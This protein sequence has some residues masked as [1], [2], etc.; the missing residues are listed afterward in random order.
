MQIPFQYDLSF[1]DVKQNNQTV[2]QT[3]R[4]EKL[5]LEANTGRLVFDTFYFNDFVALNELYSLQGNPSSTH[6][7]DNINVDA[8]TSAAVSPVG[9]PIAAWLLGSALIGFVGLRRK[10]LA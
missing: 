4:L 1:T 7:F 5:Q 6:E 2:S 3:F 8:F 10:Q 9:A